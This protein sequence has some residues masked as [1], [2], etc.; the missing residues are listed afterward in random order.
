M[1][2]ISAVLIAKDERDTIARCV[3]SLKGLDQIVVLDTGSSDMT[4]LLASNEGAEVHQGCSREP[5]HFAEAR[6]EAIKHAT[7]DWILSI[8]ADETLRPGSIAAL[9]DAVHSGDLEGFRVLHLDRGLDTRKFRF[10]KRNRFKWRYRIH[11][12]LEPVGAPT[13]IGRIDDASIEHLPPPG[14]QKSHRNIPLLRLCVE[15]SPEH[16]AALMKLG[17]ELM[18]A[19]QPEDAMEWLR[20]YSER[21]EPS[22]DAKS[23]ALCQI[24]RILGKSRDLE[25]AL[26]EFEK[27]H[28]LA[29]LRRE[30]LWYASVELIKNA[31][32]REAKTFLKACISIPESA[33]GDFELNLPALW[34]KLPHETLKEC[35]AMLKSAEQAWRIRNG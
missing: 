34:G 30:P 32:L 35:E 8:D 2:T 11:E 27:A 15:E 9:R 26:D 22:A 17:M 33:R 6:N 7:S 12:I 28:Q 1:T 29:P 24:G 3:R 20:K 10:F 19:G 18:G 14:K 16:H 21:E 13:R 31:K 5:F 4:P 25:G 23:E